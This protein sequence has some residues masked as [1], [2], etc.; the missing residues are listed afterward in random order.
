MLLWPPSRWVLGSRVSRDASVLSRT[1]HRARDT[2]GESDR[3]VAVKK[4]L[5]KD[6]NSLERGKEQH[7]EANR[8][9]VYPSERFES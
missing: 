1:Q 2:K 8:T 6:T 5:D 9:N 7:V 3:W 4:N